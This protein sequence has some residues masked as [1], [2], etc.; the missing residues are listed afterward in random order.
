M[1]QTKDLVSI[2]RGEKAVLFAE[3]GSQYLD[4][5]SSWWVNLHGHCHPYIMAKIQEQL[6]QL[7]HVSFADFTHPAAIKL[8][9]KLIEQLP[10]MGKVFYSDNGSTAVEIAIKMAL[11]YRKKGTLVAFRGS[12]HGETFG[13]MSASGK[14]ELNKP[15]WNHLFDVEIIDPPFPGREEESLKQL[16]RC[17]EAACFIYEPLVMGVGGMRSYSAEGLKALLD[18]CRREEILTIADEVMTGFGRL[19][20]LFASN[21]LDPDMICLAKGLSGG[22][23][24]LAATVCKDFIYEAFLSPHFSHA[25]LHGHSYTANPLGCAAALA[26]LEL[27]LTSEC[28]L[29]RDTIA[30]SHLRF[31]E[32]PHPRVKRCE[33]FGTILALEYQV[34][35]STYFHPIREKLYQFFLNRGILLRPLGNVLY[36]LPPYCITPSELQYIYD[37][38]VLSFEVI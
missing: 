3:D 13:A 2:V 32:T 8:A 28:S 24:P 11:Q 15:F 17:K 16:K 19:N 14:H 9:K 6:S 25:F 1:F 18:Y 12:F 31:C 10:G 20:N 7:E 33:A 36:V 23:L 26:S 34:K 27:L 37:Q 21:G 29:Q 4:G 35:E 30:K 38:I 5:T 22:F